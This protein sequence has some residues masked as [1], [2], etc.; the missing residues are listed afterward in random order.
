MIAPLSR[1]R[2]RRLFAVCRWKFCRSVAT[3]TSL[4]DRK[5]RLC[6]KHYHYATVVLADPKLRTVVTPTHMMPPG[7][8]RWRER[9]RFFPGVAAAMAEQWGEWWLLQALTPTARERARR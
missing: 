4:R 8:N 1:A 2:Q 5:P 6:G 7:P 3:E 9:S